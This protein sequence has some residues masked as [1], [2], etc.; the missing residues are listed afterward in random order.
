MPKHHVLKA[1]CVSGVNAP[2]IS[3]GTTWK[4]LLSATRSG[5]FTSLVK[6]P[7]LEADLSLKVQRPVYK[8]GLYVVAIKKIGAQLLICFR[9]AAPWKRLVWCF[10][11]KLH[12]FCI[13]TLDGNGW[14]ASRSDHILPLLSTTHWKRGLVGTQSLSGRG[15]PSG[16]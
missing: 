1:Y 8:V 10:E 4:S 13:S 2:R 14:W 7:D 16:L 11:V 9:S 3:W 5:C 6:R 15:A 12:T